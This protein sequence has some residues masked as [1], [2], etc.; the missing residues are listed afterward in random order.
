MSVSVA[1][2]IALSALRAA[3]VGLSVSSAN[4]ANADVDGYTVKTA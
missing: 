3:Q 2:S 4:I 1:S